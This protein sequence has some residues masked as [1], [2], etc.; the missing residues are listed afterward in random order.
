MCQLF[1][2]RYRFPWLELPYGNTNAYAVISISMPWTTITWVIALRIQTTYRL[3]SEHQV[4]CVHARCKVTRPGCQDE[5]AESKTVTLK[6]SCLE[7]MT[8][9]M[10][11]ILTD[12]LIRS[13]QLLVAT[14]RSGW[15]GGN[16]LYNNF[17]VRNGTLSHMV[18]SNWPV[19]N[20]TSGFLFVLYV[21]HTAAIPAFVY[22]I[23]GLTSLD[24]ASLTLM[25][26]AG[27]FRMKR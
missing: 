19:K 17:I 18:F 13:L 3:P 1:I 14:R 15:A 6:E 23:L 2:S 9:N 22:S 25:A 4:T 21:I 26:S 10:K 7:D 8:I 27:L 20:I 24:L 5:K 11:Y 12:N 16:M